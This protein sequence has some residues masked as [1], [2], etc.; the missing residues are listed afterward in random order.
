MLNEPNA[1]FAELVIEARTEN[2]SEVTAFVESC[3]EDS[4]CSV[5]TQMQIALAV[6]EIYINVASYA[7][8]P[9]TGSVTVQVEHTPE[10]LVITFIDGGVPYDP[11]AKPDPDITLS[12][13]ERQIGG[14]GIFMTKKFMDDVAYA[15]RDGKNVLTL[16]KHL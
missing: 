13:Q 15:Y 9:G 3:L 6:E 14:L 1:A 8:A 2:L 7:Y 10:L 11:L 16:T 12:A 5:K 4:A